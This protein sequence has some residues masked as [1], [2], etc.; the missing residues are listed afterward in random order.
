MEVTETW[1]TTIDNPYDFFDDFDR[2]YA[3]DI[4]MGYDTCGLIDR[5]AKTAIEESSYNTNKEIE[6]VCDKLAKWNLNGLYKKITKTYKL[7]Q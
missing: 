5:V 4:S 2:W 7:E 6:R 3:Y 1:L